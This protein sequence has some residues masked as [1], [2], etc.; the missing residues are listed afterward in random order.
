M[1]WGFARRRGALQ[2]MIMFHPLK[3]G[4]IMPMHL[5]LPRAQALETGDF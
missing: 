3:G 2:G 5:R 4:N 1:K